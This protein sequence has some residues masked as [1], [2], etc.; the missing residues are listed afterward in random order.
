MKTRKVNEIKLAFV[1]RG[2]GDPIL[3]VH[4]FPLD[5]T[6]WSAQIDVLAES[7][8]VIAPDLRGF[9]QSGVTDGVVTMQ[10]FAEDLV[11][12]L[13]ALKITE[14]ITLC[15]LSIGGY[16]AFQFW[17]E[18]ADRLHRLILCDT[19]AAA[20]SPEKAAG[21][22]EAADRVLRE[23]AAPL[24]DAMIPRLL[25]EDHSQQNSRCVDSLRRVM[26]HTDPRG[27]AAAARGMAQ[28]TDMTPILGKIQCPTLVM[29][30]AED[31]I[32]PVEEMRSMAEA[33]P[34]AQF[35]EIA[36]AAHLS[37]MEK[38]TKANAAIRKFLRGS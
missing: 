9:G 30:G 15:G 20:D 18:Y 4:G 11:A 2:K 38:P 22:W 32:S 31:T 36:G 14:P 23:G 27:I 1:A 28:R 34:D 26:L 25:A 19:R 37:P 21:R 29:V 33:I 35:V 10:Q 12:L 16:I 7:H 17:H 24:V 6:M 8:R 3:L 13:D 5:H